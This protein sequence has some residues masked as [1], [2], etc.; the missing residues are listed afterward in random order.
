MLAGSAP[1][2]LMTDGERIYFC[3]S[4]DVIEELNTWPLVSW[5]GWWSTKEYKEFGIFEK[6]DKKYDEY[7]KIRA[8]KQLIILLNPYM[9][10]RLYRF[11]D[12]LRVKEIRKSFY[13][14][15]QI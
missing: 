2:F 13:Q 12:G 6:S 5:R 3:R 1:R 11:P 4:E 15:T 10:H 9:A 14:G 8:N 7:I